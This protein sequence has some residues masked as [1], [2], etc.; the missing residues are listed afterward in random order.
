MSNANLRSVLRIKT[1][2]RAAS[3]GTSELFSAETGWEMAAAYERLRQEARKLNDRAG[4]GNGD[5]FDQELPPLD[6][7]PAAVA[8]L[9]GSPPTAHQNISRG[10]RARVLLGQ[11]EAWA[12]GHQEA[13]ELEARFKAD[14]EA[15]RQAPAG[16]KPRIGFG[17][18]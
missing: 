16:A 2:A 12:E 5:E 10:R 4:W 8:R 11:L 7:D 17:A 15:K 9:L 14:A 18:D 13:F 3:A 1:M 6:S